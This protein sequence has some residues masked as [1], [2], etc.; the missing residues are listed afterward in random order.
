MKRSAVFLAGITLLLASVAD[1]A[2]KNR[3]RPTQRNYDERREWDTRHPYKYWPTP[4]NNRP[5]GP[6]AGWPGAGNRITVGTKGLSGVGAGNTLKSRVPY[7][8]QHATNGVHADAAVGGGSRIGS[9]GSGQAAVGPPGAGAINGSSRFGK[10]PSA[11]VD[12]GPE[13]PE[14]LQEALDDISTSWKKRDPKGIRSRLPAQNSVSIYQD[15][16]FGYDVPAS[17]LSKQLNVGVQELQT[18]IFE[19]NVPIKETATRYFVAGRH[20]FLDLGGQKQSFH[21][22][23]VLEKPADRWQIAEYGVSQRPIN[24]HSPKPAKEEAFAPGS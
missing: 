20:T 4:P 24:R 9:Y 6:R 1:A 7:D 8:K 10:K 15:G 5:T 17:E 19:L 11:E 18:Q 2:P 12:Q 23:Y 3:Q 14:G 13:L 22:S 21:V 16:A